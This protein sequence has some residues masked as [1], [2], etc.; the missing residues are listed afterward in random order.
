MTTT[1]PLRNAL[2]RSTASSA[3]A[4]VRV[5]ARLYGFAAPSPAIDDGGLDPDVMRAAAVAEHAAALIAETRLPSL[6][7]VRAAK[8]RHRL[9]PPSS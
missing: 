5:Y 1:D 6:K 9:W 3:A 8:I 4:K 2:A 7:A